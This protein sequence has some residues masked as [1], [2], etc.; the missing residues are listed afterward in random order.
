MKRRT[1]LA[2]L[3][4]VVLAVACHS[5]EP[6]MVN[7]HRVHW[8]QTHASTL[9]RRID[10]VVPRTLTGDT[11]FMRGLNA[12]VAQVNRSPYIRLDV[13]VVRV[14]PSV[15]LN[16]HCIT[17]VRRSMNGAYARLGWNSAGHIYGRGAE[18]G[19]DTAPWSPAVLA[20][21]ACH[22]LY[23]TLG[24]AH[25]SDGTP[26]PCQGG[27]A[28]AVD[29]DNVR[30]AHNHRDRIIYGSAEEGRRR[31]LDLRTI[32]H[33]TRAELAEMAE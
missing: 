3:A 11:A 5:S 19:F 14:A 2:V 29:L 13:H 33:S 1:A 15:C 4:V 32:D 25:S 7:G 8:Q 23:H 12:G 26:G 16:R 17:V 27:V 6:F 18:I 20:N 31:P 21:A 10:L 24:L 9:E 30:L 28:T 22:E